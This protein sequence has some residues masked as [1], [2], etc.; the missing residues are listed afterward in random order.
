MATDKDEHGF[1]PGGVGNGSSARLPSPAGNP[2]KGGVGQLTGRLGQRGSSKMC[3]GRR[4]AANDPHSGG[5]AGTSRVRRRTAVRS[6]S[7]VDTQFSTKAGN[8]VSIRRVG[9]SGNGLGAGF[10]ESKLDAAGTKAAEVRLTIREEADRAGCFAAAGFKADESERPAPRSN[11]ST[12]CRCETPAW[13]ISA[14]SVQPLEP[15]FFSLPKKGSKQS[16]PMF[17]W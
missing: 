10:Q 14:H 17:G 11:T 13:P 4:Q 9:K 16:P 15:G 5:L 8:R 6:K 7:A 12:K 2:R 1:Q 3:W